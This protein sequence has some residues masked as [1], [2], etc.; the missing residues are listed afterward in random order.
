VAG[1]EI[2]EFAFLNFGIS[3][4][5]TES[6]DRESPEATH[7]PGRPAQTNGKPPPSVSRS[8][9]PAQVDEHLIRWQA[10]KS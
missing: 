2:L 4:P 7:S 8:R 10:S 9:A 6:T 3:S 5:V 1:F